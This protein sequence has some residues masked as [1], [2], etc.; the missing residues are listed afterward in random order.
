MILKMKKKKNVVVMLIIDMWGDVGA[1]GG[2][3]YVRV[4]I[5][6]FTSLTFSLRF[7]LRFYAFAVYSECCFF[8]CVCNVLLSCMHSIFPTYI[9]LRNDT[10]V[11]ICEKHVGAFTCFSKYSLKHFGMAI[12]MHCTFKIIYLFNIY[13]LP[14]MLC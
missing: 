6:S 1:Q 12:L 7:W 10:K 2:G 5:R 11:Q 3:R 9:K 14:C 13:I 8:V 4:L